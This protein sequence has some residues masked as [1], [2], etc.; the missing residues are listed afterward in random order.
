[1]EF[2]ETVNAIEIVTELWIQ[3][4]KDCVEDCVNND[5]SCFIL[6][7]INEH[8]KKEK[9]SRYLPT[10]HELFWRKYGISKES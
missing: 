9:L 6:Y 10:T 8:L 1:M 7:R 3:A 2:Q 5:T 4:C